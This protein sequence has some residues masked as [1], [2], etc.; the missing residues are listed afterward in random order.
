MNGKIWPR[1]PDVAGQ[2]SPP[3]IV[4]SDQ[5]ARNRYADDRLPRRGR[6][7]PGL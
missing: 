6:A 1:Q 4:E 5:A 2:L 3:P 7:R